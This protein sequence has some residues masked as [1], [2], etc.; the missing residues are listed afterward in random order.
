MSVQL[1]Y[2]FD[3]TKSK[4]F[5]EGGRRPNGRLEG[6]ISTYSFQEKIWIWYCHIDYVLGESFKLILIRSYPLLKD[7]VL[8][9]EES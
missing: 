1:Y 3:Q 7:C 2:F 5:F 4:V 8:N 6:L 9:I